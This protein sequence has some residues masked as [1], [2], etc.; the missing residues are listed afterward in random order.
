MR[1]IGR[2]KVGKVTEFGRRWIITRLT[3]GYIVTVG[4]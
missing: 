3:K 4:K 1:A 2:G